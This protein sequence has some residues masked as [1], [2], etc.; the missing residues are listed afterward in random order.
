MV[1]IDLLSI[2]SPILILH[3]GRTAPTTLVRGRREGWVRVRIAGQTDWKHLWMAVMSGPPQ[4]GPGGSPRPE[5]PP[6]TQHKRRISSLFSRDSNQP[7]PPPTRSLV[8]FYL[9]PRPKDKRKPFLTLYD[10]TQAF[11]VYPERP[12]LINKSTLMKIEGTFGEE[13]VAMAMRRREGW[14]LV[15]PELEV[16]VPQANE[17]IRWLIG[18]VPPHSITVVAYVW[19]LQL[20]MMHSRYMDGLGPTLGI[21]AIK[22]R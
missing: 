18:M 5:S 19:P 11:A 12:E 17:T 4:E 3:I 1:C 15:M 9:S 22:R 13:E 8:A 16:G 14:V 7:Q 21:L 2:T 6:E 20:F 10:L